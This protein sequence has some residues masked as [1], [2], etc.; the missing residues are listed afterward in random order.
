MKEKRKGNIIASQQSFKK[1]IK[2]NIS[3]ENTIP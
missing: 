2:Q 3:R 1:W